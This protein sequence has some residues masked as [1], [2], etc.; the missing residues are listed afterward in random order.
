MS[1]LWFRACTRVPAGPGALAVQ[2]TVSSSP[3]LRL[4]PR[5]D[6]LHVA[7]HLRARGP[8][9]SLQGSFPQ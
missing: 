5:V 3:A 7:E 1:L 4:S 6:T 2:L 8:G 9:Q